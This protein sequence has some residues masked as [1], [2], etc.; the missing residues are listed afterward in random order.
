MGFLNLAAHAIGIP[1]HDHSTF[2]DVAIFYFASKH[3]PIDFSLI[4]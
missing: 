2:D 4:L 3:M 1:T